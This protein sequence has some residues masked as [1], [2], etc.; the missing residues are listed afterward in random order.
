MPAARFVGSQQSKQ[1]K[2]TEKDRYSCKC[3]TPVFILSVFFN[4]NRPSM[5]F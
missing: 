5:L 4:I 3:K 1:C 2:R